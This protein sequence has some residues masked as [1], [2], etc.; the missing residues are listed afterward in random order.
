MTTVERLP[1]QHREAPH[2]D[3]CG[4]SLPTPKSLG[5][6]LSPHGLLGCTIVSLSLHVRCPCGAEHVLTQKVR[7]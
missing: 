6:I 4:S 1:V 3:E 5:M 7:S 2:C